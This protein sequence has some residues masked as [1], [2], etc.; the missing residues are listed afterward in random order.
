MEASAP[1]IPADELTSRYRT[2][3]ASAA[4]YA[5]LARRVIVSK[6][7]YL[8]SFIG[9]V[10]FDPTVAAVLP[11]VAIS[12]IPIVLIQHYLVTRWERNVRSASFYRRALDRLEGHWIDAGDLGTRY[13]EADHP[14][15]A[16]LDIF[17]RGSLFQLLCTPCTAQGRDMLA[18]W[19]KSPAPATSVLRRQEAVRELRDQIDL[20]ESLDLAGAR[21]PVDTETHQSLSR[22][23]P[24]LASRW[25]RLCAPLLAWV[26]LASCYVALT[27]GG[28]WSTLF[29]ICLGIE[30]VAYIAARNRIL[31]VAGRGHQIGCSLAAAADVAQILQREHWNSALLQDLQFVIRHPPRPLHARRASALGL[32][33]QLPAAYFLAVQLIP[34]FERRLLFR[35]RQLPPFWNAIGQCEVLAAFA[36]HAFENPADCLPELDT[37]QPCFDARELGHP[38]ID[39]LNVVRNDVRLG[40]PLQLLMVSG[41]NMSGKSTLL[42]TVGVN[43]VLALAGASVRAQSLRISPLVIGT[44]MRFQDSLEEGTSY[45]FNVLARL[46]IVL[47]LLTDERPLLFLFDEILQGTNSHDRLAGAEAVIRKL[48][49]AGAIGLVTTHDLELTRVADHLAPAAENVHFVD[50]V[51]D[52]QLLFDFRM[53]TGV[54]QSS[55]AIR[56]MRDMGLDV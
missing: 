15:A 20:R 48:L 33:C 12:L 50:T 11:P 26:T 41:S 23:A 39:T 6:R 5:R 28:D 14:Y 52:G 10:V 19:L 34:G 27:R 36:Q 24:L 7:V 45:F 2:R 25:S 22:V 32:F 51:E 49:S 35:L 42:R 40:D 3:R 8:A 29:Y 43:A 18:A 1:P 30:A 55:N 37:S 4:R 54:V 16:D 21:K 9:Y 17:G 53:R 56:L 44:A 47:D 13:Q 38:L 31:D 46:R